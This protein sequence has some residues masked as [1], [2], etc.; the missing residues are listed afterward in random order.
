MCYFKFELK[1]WNGIYFQQEFRKSHGK[2]S[3]LE[4]L[5]NKDSGFNANSFIK[6]SYIK[7]SYVLYCLYW[8]PLK[9]F[10]PKKLNAEEGFCLEILFWGL[11]N[12]SPFND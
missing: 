9:K 5:F 2:T 4:S 1:Q 8:H 7:K 11:K 10:M 12:K 3:A 6:K